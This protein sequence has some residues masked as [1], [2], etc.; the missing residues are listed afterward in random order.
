MLNSDTIGAKQ[1]IAAKNM[2]ISAHPHQEI[3]CSGRA[4]KKRRLASG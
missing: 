2:Q 3:A 1:G 4:A